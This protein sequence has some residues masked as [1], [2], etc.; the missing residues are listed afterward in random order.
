MTEILSTPV[1]TGGKS[2]DLTASV[3]RTVFLPGV[4]TLLAGF[5]LNTAGVDL[6]ALQLPAEL[7]IGYLGYTVVRGLEV[8]ASPKWGYILGLPGH[9]SYPGKPTA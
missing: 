3:I 1:V 7:V 2:A 6:G 8:Y 9:P 4:L 5:G